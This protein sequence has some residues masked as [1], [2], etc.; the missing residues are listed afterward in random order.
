M[1]R[2][3]GAAVIAGLF[4][5]LQGCAN[6]PCT[7]CAGL[8]TQEATGTE[9]A[10]TGGDSSLS[11]ILSAAI[12]VSAI[13]FTN[14]AG[15]T[16]QILTQPRTLQVA[17][18]GAVQSLIEID[19]LPWG[20]Y[21][22]VSVTVSAA[23][24]TFLR[25]AGVSAAPAVVPAATATES[26]RLDPPLTVSSIN[27]SFFQLGLDF[28][29]AQS[30]DFTNNLVSFTP[31]LSAAA[32]SLAS[33]AQAVPVRI[34]GVVISAAGPEGAGDPYGTVKL[35]VPDTGL[36]FTMLTNAQTQW[37]DN[38][39]A[40]TL[41]PGTAIEVFA[42]LAANVQPL[43]LSI[44]AA[45]GGQPLQSG[46]EAL[47]GVVTGVVRSNGA[48]QSIAMVVQLPLV[49]AGA[50]PPPLGQAVSVTTDAD[51]TYGP[52]I[53]AQAAGLPG[54]DSSQIFP[55]AGVLVT[56][57]GTSASP[58]GVTAADVRSGP[59]SVFGLTSGAVATTSGGYSFS[60]QLNPL[61]PFANASGQTSL[62]VLTN[63][64]TQ[65]GGQGLTAATAGALAAG[66]PLTVNGFVAMSGP[67]GY[68]VYAASVLE[69]NQ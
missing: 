13:T 26:V 45:N 5:S 69:E 6:G 28:D 20:T 59:V 65:F 61:D 33:A 1:H 41:Q 14:D 52:S 62:T 25:T 31:V 29:L 17:S 8:P 60:L 2:I 22:G 10:L 9:I 16:T 30:F 27:P 21:T 48:L 55:G 38:L 66:T 56:T 68:T 34:V 57:G 40:N 37:S 43:A 35:E 18:L 64:A 7:E 39:S 42:E 47:S 58:G 11:G 51:T 15:A 44:Q 50:I 4:F 54:F 32:T 49:P 67:G 53:Q 36:V 24:V 3:I 23:S 12:T 63:A 46:Q 19:G